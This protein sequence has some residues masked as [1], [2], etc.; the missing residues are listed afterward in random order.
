MPVLRGAP[1]ADR[2]A[3]A[4]EVD[5]LVHLVGRPVDVG[6]EA[7]ERLF[8]RQ[9]E[10]DVDED[11]AV[12]ADQEEHLE[13]LSPAVVAAVRGLVHLLYQHIAPDVEC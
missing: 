10:D 1:P 13:A 11:D 6:V 5:A 8:D 4:V 7:L 2:D 12:V 3:D 9:Q